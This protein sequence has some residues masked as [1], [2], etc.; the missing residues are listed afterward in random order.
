MAT[1]LSRRKIAHYVATE[2]A[3]G[4]SLDTLL[5]E[6]AALLVD[7]GRTRE[8]ELLVRDIE[9]AL[10]SEGIVVADVTT[11]GAHDSSIDTILKRLVPGAKQFVTRYHSDEKVLGGVLLELPGRQLDATVRG[12]LDKLR[13]VGK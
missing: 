10:A 4:A 5:E 9:E 3:H 1:R 12:R 2:V 7:T 8:Y 6:V 13:H 11:A